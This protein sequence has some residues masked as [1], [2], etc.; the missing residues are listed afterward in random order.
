MHVLGAAVI[1]MQC[2][3]AACYVV[4]FASNCCSPDALLLLLLQ[5]AMLC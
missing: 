4:P 1:C 2:L 5:A 3:S